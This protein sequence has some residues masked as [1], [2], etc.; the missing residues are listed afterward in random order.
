MLTPAIRSIYRRV[1][2]IGGFATASLAAGGREIHDDKRVTRRVRL[3]VI[4]SEPLCS[5]C[6]PCSGAAW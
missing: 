2:R 1:K 6:E 4:R 5:F 3:I